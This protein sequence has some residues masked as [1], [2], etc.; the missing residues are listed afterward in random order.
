MDKSTQTYE[1]VAKVVG[2]KRAALAEAEAALAITMEALN[3]KKAELKEVEDGLKELQD[4]FSAGERYAKELQ[5]DV[6]L[7]ALKLER[8]TQLI[9]GLGGEKARWELFVED[10]N[11]QCTYNVKRKLESNLPIYLWSYLRRLRPFLDSAMRFCCFHGMVTFISP[12][13]HVCSRDLS[14]NS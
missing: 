1:R 10:L 13:F 5:D 8:A 4:K 11:L 9:T 3:A 2:P 14:N 6:A 12:N 7:C